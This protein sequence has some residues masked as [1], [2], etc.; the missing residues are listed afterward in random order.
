MDKPTAIFREKTAQHLIKQLQR[1]R[2]EASYAPTIAQAK[3]EVLA[4]ITPN[5][6][7]FRCGS[8][9]VGAVG[10]WEEMAKLPGVVVINPYQPGIPPEEG[11]ARRVA[12]MSADFMVA[13]TNAITLDGK[14][15]NLDGMGNR[16]AAMIFGPKKVIL[17]VGMNKLVSD[18]EAAM[19]RVKDIAAPMNNLRL[20]VANPN[21]KNPCCETGLCQDCHSPT[22]IC[23][24]WSIIEGHMIKDRIH[25]KLVG[26][27]LG[28]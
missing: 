1:R 22:R 6:K 15:V 20:A 16:V 23:N 17:L 5:S 14:L 3:A 10:L 18:V 9:S 11:M 21:F 27:D 26:E 19:A 4:M 28:Y 13:S 12:G 25:V 24:A 7:V 8:E 2:M